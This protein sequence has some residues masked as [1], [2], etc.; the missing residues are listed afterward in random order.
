MISFEL[1]KII[2][3]VIALAY[4]LYLSSSSKQYLRIRDLL[5]IGLILWISPIISE[6]IWQNELHPMQISGVLVFIY[7]WGIFIVEKFFEGLKS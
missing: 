5:I 2:I 7:A 1:I 3:G 6:M 4:Y